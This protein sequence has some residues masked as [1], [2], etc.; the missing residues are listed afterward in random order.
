MALDNSI[1][2]SLKQKETRDGRKCWKVQWS[3]RSQN[4]VAKA[5]SEP[6]DYSFRDDLINFTVAYLN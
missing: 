1:N 6:K 3:K 4:F 5:L 2:A